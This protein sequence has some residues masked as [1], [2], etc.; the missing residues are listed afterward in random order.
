MQKEKSLKVLIISFFMACMLLSQPQR[1]LAQDAHLKQA[2]V[3]ELVK[4]TRAKF[5]VPAIAVMV[6]NSDKVY[7]QEIQ[8]VRVFDKPETVTLDDY[9]HLGSCSKSILAFIAAKYV[10]QKKITWNTQFFDVFPELRAKARSEYRNITLEDLLTCRAGIKAYT[11]SQI[12][13]FPEYGPLVKEPRMEFI[14][15][16]ITQSPATKKQNGKFEYLYSNASYTMASAMLERISKLKYEDFVKKVMTDDL[17]ITVHI[18]WPNAISPDQPWGHWIRDGK[19]ESLGP[20]HD[21]KIPAFIMPAGDL[22]MT[23]KDYA[24]YIQLQLRGLCGADNYISRSTYKLLHFGH[25]GFSIGMGN[26]VEKGKRF[27][28][29]NGSGGTFFCREIIFPDCDFAF[30]IMMNQGDGDAAKWLS[31]KIIE[32]RFK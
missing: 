26:S 30:T 31:D 7:I 25:K 29:F 9:F 11:N 2:D 23:P 20:D 4:E 5:H 15:L 27:S 10:E 16:L 13:H 1:S 24:K 28:F 22:S 18:G 6:M 17:G 12:D 32:K 8:G 14:K 3:S 19:I 21:Y